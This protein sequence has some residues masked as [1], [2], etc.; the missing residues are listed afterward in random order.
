MLK[1]N[2]HTA[3]LAIAAVVLL[4]LQLWQ[5]AVWTDSVALRRVEDQAASSLALYATGMQEAVGKY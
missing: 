2:K 5:I 3:L 4:P 1:Q